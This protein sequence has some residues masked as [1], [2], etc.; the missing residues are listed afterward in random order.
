MNAL[1]LLNIG[2]KKL[3]RERIISSKID[4]ELLLSN[5]VKVAHFF[6]SGCCVIEG[7]NASET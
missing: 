5:R 6:S 4:S 3:E 1:E 2:T 7:G